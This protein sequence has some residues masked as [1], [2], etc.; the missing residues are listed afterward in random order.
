MDSVSDAAAD[1]WKKVREQAAPVV[2][3]IKP[4]LDAAAA[5]AK[6]DPVRAAL[7]LAAAGAIIAGLVAMTRS[8]QDD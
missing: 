8:S 1:A 4:Q 6:D 7:G 3:R 5:Y 2:D